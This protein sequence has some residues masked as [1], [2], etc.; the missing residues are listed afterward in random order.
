MYAVVN[1]G[2][3]GRAAA[4]PNVR[5]CGKTG[6]AQL[7]SNQFLKGSKLGQTMKDNG[8]FVAFAPEEAPEIVVV[9]LYENGEHGDR[10]AWVVRDVMK[11]YFDKKERLAKSRPQLAEAARPPLVLPFAAPAAFL[12]RKS[13]P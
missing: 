4:L 2:G 1:E 11:A 5:V 8:W 3:T 6:S 10:A 7:A 9:G 12:T 13:I